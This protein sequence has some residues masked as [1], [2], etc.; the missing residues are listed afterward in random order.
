[1]KWIAIVTPIAVLVGLILF[2]RSV[3]AKLET[4]P[5]VPD[6]KGTDEL[7]KRIY[8]NFEFFVKVFLALVS[9]FGYVKFN[10]QTLGA[11][12]VR[13]ALVAIAL[14]GLVTMVAL[15]VSVASLQ[16][17]KIPR[18][19]NYNK[20]FIWTWQEIYMMLAMYLLWAGL[21]YLAFFW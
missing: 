18:W 1:M 15:V 20:S 6:N 17:W 5:K 19:T 16:A 2:T 13:L 11:P 12:T 4:L 8:L 21:W 7:S 14:M 9:G 10:Q 3:W